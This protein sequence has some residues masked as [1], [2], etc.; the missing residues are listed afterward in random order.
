MRSSSEHAVHRLCRELVEPAGLNATP[1]RDSHALP[2]V[3]Y[4]TTARCAGAARSTGRT[5][6]SPAPIGSDNAANRAAGTQSAH[7]QQKP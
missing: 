7:P 4:S 2:T 5:H 1:H 3:P 6:R